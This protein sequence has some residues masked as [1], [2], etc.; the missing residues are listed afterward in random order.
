MGRPGIPSSDMGYLDYIRVE[1]AEDLLVR[2]KVLLGFNLGFF[3]DSIPCDLFRLCSWGSG[4][5]V[6]LYE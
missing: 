1:Y 4:G 3:K 6:Q 5:G 2:C